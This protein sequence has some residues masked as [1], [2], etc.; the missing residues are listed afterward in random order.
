MYRENGGIKK[1]SLFYIRTTQVGLQSNVWV[2]AGQWGRAGQ[3]R[4]M[5]L[6]KWVR[7]LVFDFKQGRGLRVG[8]GGGRRESVNQIKSENYCNSPHARWRT[9]LR[10]WQGRGGPGE[11]QKS[12]LLASH[13]APWM[14]CYLMNQGAQGQ[15]GW[16][17]GTRKVPS[18]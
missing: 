8:C 5:M 14:G 2:K 1:N 16:N 18:V 15:A 9:S 4:K 17:K 11:G 3:E 7:A 10:P 13:S 12:K 6:E